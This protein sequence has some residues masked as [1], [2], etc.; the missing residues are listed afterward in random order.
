MVKNNQKRDIFGIT[1]FI[2]TEI[3]ILIAIFIVK[4]Q[5]NDDL[6]FQAASTQYSFWDFVYYHEYLNWSGRISANGLF[7]LSTKL[8]IWTYK[9]IAPLSI[10][11]TSYSISKFFTKK[12]NLRYILLI[13]LS[14]SLISHR[15]LGESLFW[16][17]GSFNYLVPVSCGLFCLIPYINN[18][19]TKKNKIGF[20][21][22]TIASLIATLGNEQIAFVMIAFILI[23]HLSQKIKKRS[24]DTSLYFLTTIIILGTVINLISPGNK[25]RWTQELHWIPGFNQL[26][27]ID[28]ISL[29]ISWISNTLLNRFF[30]ILLFLSSIPILFKE[31]LKK[32]TKTFYFFFLFQFTTLLLIK[33][34][35]NF[36][37]IPKF[38]FNP[39]WILYLINLFFLII[40]SSSKKIFTFEC[41]MAGLGS[42]IIMWFSPTIYASSD[43]V[44]YVASIF[45]IIVIISFLD[46]LKLITKNKIT[47]LFFILFT[48]SFLSPLIKNLLNFF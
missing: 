42:L 11:L 10:F 26:S 20:F 30:L 35:S 3:V 28:H 24:I 15:I 13:T 1:L 45:W 41:L 25:I 46:Q 47:T 38:F 29:G 17:T 48:G 36:I 32:K 6:Q 7:Y 23:F 37:Q 12:I 27:T 43:R 14:F 40:Q 33:I 5:P 4:I 18:S 19:C 34:I 2:L 9:L 21:F 39:F 44:M 22:I 8:G 16:F 31:K